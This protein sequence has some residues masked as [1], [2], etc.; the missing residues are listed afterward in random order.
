MGFGDDIMATAYAAAVRN[1]LQHTKIVFGDG[2]RAHWS[3]VFRHNPN[4]AQPG[5]PSI[6]NVSWVKDYPGH[7]HY[8]DYAGE[9]TR[10]FP[11]QAGFSGAGPA[12]SISQTRSGDARTVTPLLLRS[13]SS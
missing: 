4:I 11:F 13:A 6:Y 8:I 5:E 2:E 7:R 12:S 3:D 1:D 10:S 9:P